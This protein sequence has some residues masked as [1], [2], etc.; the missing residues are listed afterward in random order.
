MPVPE[1]NPYPNQK[2]FGGIDGLEGGGIAP[3]KFLAATRP[4]TFEGGR[5]QEV[6]YTTYSG[7]DIV[8]EIVLPHERITL[9]ELQT[10]SYSIHRENSP[11]R[12]LGHVNP[13]GFVKGPRTIAGSLIFTVFNYY[14][15]YRVKQ[16]GQSIASGFYPLSDMLPP[17][18]IVVT[19]ANENGAMSKL[20]LYGIAM[21]QEGQTMSVDDLIVE[22]T[23]QYIARGIQPMTSYS[24]S[25][26][27][28]I[29]RNQ[30]ATTAMGFNT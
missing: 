29:N 4:S 18:D 6:I 10:L 19:F 12:T 17:F 30:Y 3:A 25:D 9:G 24:W 27:P 1:V 13:V 21:I 16:F 15:F 5:E 26:A 7:V 2:N 22:Q 14:A 23:Y 11:V 20:K 8:A 28:T